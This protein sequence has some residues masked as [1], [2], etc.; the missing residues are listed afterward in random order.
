MTIPPRD[1]DDPRSDEPRAEGPWDALLRAM[2]GPDADAVLRDLSA[3]G[4]MPDLSAIGFVGAD[5]TPLDLE[6]MAAA[7]GVANDPEALNQVLGQI[8]R[9]L[10][11][12]LI[13]ISEPTRLGMLS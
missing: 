4:G 6:A 5:G 2:L 11:L 3:R 9:V 10:D 13:H 12:S 1:D 7:A 8:K